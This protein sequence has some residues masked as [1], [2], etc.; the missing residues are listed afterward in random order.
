MIP[1][2]P[3][4][5]V[6]PIAPFQYGRGFLSQY[7][8]NLHQSPNSL[9]MNPYAASSNNYYQTNPPPT[10]SST[11]HRPTTTTAPQTTTTTTTSSPSTTTTETTTTFQSQQQDQFAQMT[12][13]FSGKSPPMISDRFNPSSYEYSS[14][15][16][17]Q[18]SAKGPQDPYNLQYVTNIAPMNVQVVKSLKVI[19][20]T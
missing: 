7:Q 18:A 1:N 5:P 6:P 4:A 12:G 13:K 14:Y 9:G 8:G 19:Q 3:V 16:A 20:D 2:N 15:N 11:T 17:A 10:P